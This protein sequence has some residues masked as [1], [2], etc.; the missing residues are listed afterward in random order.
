MFIKPHFFDKC[1]IL[2]TIFKRG[3]NMNEEKVDRRIRKTKKALLQCLTKLMSEKKISDITVK[4]L[5]D[6]ADVNRSTFYLY[7]KDIFDM[8]ERIE[9][10]MFEEFL[11]IFNESNKGK[12]R[13]SSL[14]ALYTYIF[15]YVESNSEICKI[16]LGPDGDYAFIQKFKKAILETNVLF[17]ESVPLNKV[18][19]YRSFI[20]TGVIGLIQQWL[21]EST[22]TSA[23]DMAIFMTD[24]NMKI[25]KFQN[26]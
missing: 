16:L 5:T 19:F 26:S 15:E 22:E 7:Y 8:V 4:E 20:L 13:Y 12:D 17:D 9:T 1:C 14:L 11:R 2:H 24:L 3:Y 10:N 23:K 6:L 25:I 21:E 18:N